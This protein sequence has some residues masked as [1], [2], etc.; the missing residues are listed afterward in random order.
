MDTCAEGVETHD[1]LQLIRELG[2]SMVQGF[3]FGRPSPAETAREL[4]NRVRVEADGYQC[5]REPRHRLIRRAIAIIDGER[6][7]MKLRNIS[8]MGA[9]A[10]CPVPV[11]PGMNVTLDIVGVGPVCGIVCWAQSGKFGIQFGEQ[12]DL[13]R[14]ALKKGPGNEVTMLRPWYVEERR[15][16]ER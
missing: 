16:S 7:D 6:I 8:S 15:A 9:L 11:A 3:I 5:I 1:D 4:A 2:V 12:F 10:E 14:L 13:G